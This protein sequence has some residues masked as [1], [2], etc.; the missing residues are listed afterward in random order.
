M[1][2]RYSNLSTSRFDPLSMEEIMAVPLAKQAQHD[3]TQTAADEY[4][5]LQSQRLSKDAEAVDSRLKELRGKADGISDSLLETGVNKNL[6]RQLRNLKR[7]KEKEF[8]Q[9]GLVGA[10]AANY[11]SATAFV[12]DLATKKEQQAGWSPARAK[13]WAESQVAGF[14]GTQNEDGTF[15]QFQGKGLQTKVDRNDWINKNL[16]NV[17]ADVS[18]IALRYAGN[19]DQFN[20]AYRSGRIKEKDFNK[21]MGSLTSMAANDTDLMA[22]L[23][24]ESFFTG[25][26]DATKIGKWSIEKGPDGKN[27]DV[28]EPGSSFGRQ[29]Y[30]A[31]QG[32]KYREVDY[33]YKIVEDKAAW[34]LYKKGMEPGEADTMVRVSEGEANTITGKEIDVLDSNIELALKQLTDSKAAIRNYKGDKN[35]REYKLMVEEQ[36]ESEKKYRSAKNRVEDIK[37]AAYTSLSSSEKSVLDTS[38][39]I[40]EDVLGMS[41]AQSARYYREKI[42][43]AGFDPEKIMRDNNIGRGLESS[44]LKAALYISRGAE[45]KTLDVSTN[46]N[47]MQSYAASV[48]SK[49]EKS[50]DDYLENNPYSESYKELAGLATGDFKS[51][52]GGINKML[53]DTFDGTNYSTA[54]GGEILD[55]TDDKYENTTKEVRVTNGYDSSG[56]PIETLVIKDEDGLVMETMQVTRGQDGLTQQRQAAEELLKSK[57]PGLRKIGQ[58][59]MINTTYMPAIKRSELRSGAQSGYIDLPGKSVE[60]NGKEL[61]IGW[62]VKDT[63]PYGKKIWKITAMDPKARADGAKSQPVWSSEDLF[64]EQEVANYLAKLGISQ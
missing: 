54:Y 45:P 30:A 31:A 3:A 37:I 64:G 12:N 35:D 5:A 11:K 20:N 49:A 62:E 55:L 48:K 59:I 22:S 6:T 36:N 43:E 56:Y 15:N 42:K 25:E 61:D 29:I 2:N 14:Q 52:I 63:G 27:R 33:S 23:Q 9:E 44:R 16:K 39:M 19:M 34:A 24:Q 1:A 17:A 41:E 51:K 7:E 38:E 32:S 60:I 46:P 53:T 28:F 57:D 47:N 8:G 10:A 18:P 21:I 4:S 58:D 13:A 26:K 40:A 50:V